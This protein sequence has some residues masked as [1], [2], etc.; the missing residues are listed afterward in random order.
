MNNEKLHGRS[1]P[2]I[3]LSEEHITEIKRGY[4]CHLKGTKIDSTYKSTAVKLLVKCSLRSSRMSCVANTMIVRGEEVVRMRDRP[5]QL[6]MLHT[7][8][9]TTQF[10]TTG[11]LFL[12]LLPSNSVRENC[13]ES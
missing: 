9:F 5:D 6:G 11:I 2:V 8:R 7:L 3:V 12:L 13:L 10:P 4:S 1:R